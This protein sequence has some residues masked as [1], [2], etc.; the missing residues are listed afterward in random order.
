MKMAPR[1]IL[2]LHENE[3]LGGK[4]GRL[5]GKEFSLQPMPSWA[6]LRDA[7]RTAPPT[8]VALVDPWLDGR[9]G[10]VSTG[11]RSLLAE[12]P[13]LPVF[14]AIQSTQEYAA[15][16]I[17][18]S[19]FDIADVITIGRD[20]STDAL[21]ER[22]HRARGRS[23][24]MILERVVPAD[25]PG[26]ADAIL[27]V[28]ADVI[29]GG[30]YARDVA[31][32]LSMSKRTLQRWVERSDLPPPRKLLAWL[33]VLQAAE[34]LDDPG[35]TVYSVARACGYSSDSALRRVTKRFLGDNP[36]DL[37]R[38]GAFP[39]AALA[40]GNALERVKIRNRHFAQK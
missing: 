13:S 31:R 26:R 33:R 11:F 35:R 17:H 21:R 23:V 1:P 29:M 8:A 22:L 7:A 15:Q 19:R 12:F 18:L 34:L 27:E 5:S 16:I 25:L 36:T 20:D 2:L 37:R 32:T 14:A 10:D 38:R 9:G 24:R 6:D 4:L 28:A 39:V 30:G 40:F 3:R